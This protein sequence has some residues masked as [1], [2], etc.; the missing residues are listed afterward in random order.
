M[1]VKRLDLL[2]RGCTILGRVLPLVVSA[3]RGYATA[4]A[5]LTTVAL[6]HTGRRDL[7]GL[8]AGD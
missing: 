8:L 5:L 7:P 6:L 1:T 3:A 4:W 2:G